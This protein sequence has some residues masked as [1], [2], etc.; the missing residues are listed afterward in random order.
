MNFRWSTKE[1]PPEPN[2]KVFQ[3]ITWFCYT[4]FSIANCIRELIWVFSSLSCAWMYKTEAI[5]LKNWEGELTD[6]SWVYCF[7]NSTISV[8]FKKYICLLSCKRDILAIVCFL[9]LSDKKNHHCLW[10]NFDIFRAL[11]EFKITID[12]YAL[13][14]VSC[15][16]V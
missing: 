2:Q 6:D 10:R 8:A 11:F 9:V 1:I 4:S 16:R 12:F 15:N 5:V 14:S 7:I 3:C 13:H